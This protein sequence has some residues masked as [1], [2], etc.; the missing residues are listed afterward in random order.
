MKMRKVPLFLFAIFVLSTLALTGTWCYT[1]ALLQHATSKYGAYPSPEEAMS[2]L[3]WDD[4]R[5]IEAQYLQ[6]SGP[7]CLFGI[8]SP[9][10]WFVHVAGSGTGGGAYFLH[11]Q[12]GWVH[13]PEIAFPEII[14]F[15]MI[16][17]G[18][19]P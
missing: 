1:T 7:S 3:L 9:H 8:C 14:G 11:T 12:D 15:G 16:L 18:L 17:Y 2:A 6:Y 4:Q 10:I 19:T 5:P 13:M